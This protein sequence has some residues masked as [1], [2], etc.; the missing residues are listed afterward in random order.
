M[1]DFALK[2]FGLTKSFS[3][4]IVL[5]NVN[6]NVRK[7]DIY[8]FI[9]KNGAGKTTLIKIVAGLLKP[10]AGSL[11]LFS[12][13]DLNKQRTRIGTIIENPSLYPNFTAKENLRVQCKLLG[14]SDEKVIDKLLDI[15]GLSDTGRKK[16]KKFSLG[17]KQRLSIAMA[18]VGDPE[19][20]ILDEPINGLDPTGIKDVRD[21]IAK[22]NSEYNKTILISCHLLGELAKIASCYGVIN[23]GKLVKEI[24]ASELEEACKECLCIKVD[25]IEKACDI[26]EN[27]INITNYESIN[28]DTINI[29][30]DFPN[31]ASINSELLSAGVGVNSIIKKDKDV[32]AY[33]IDL[34]EGK[35]ND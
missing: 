14:V 3:G 9:G 10:T 11:E 4:K 2:T 12:S 35:T 29:Y 19:F 1:M 15:V 16:A 22:L 5:D 13:S 6:L 34:M 18:L 24:T 26:L 33:F 23:E 31:S 17:M 20:L 25:N 28:E 7:G 32:E 8:G 30:G 27:K 21:L